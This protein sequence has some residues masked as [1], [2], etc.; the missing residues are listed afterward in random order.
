MLVAFNRLSNRLI[1][2]DAD[3]LSCARKA[4]NAVYAVKV[5]YGNA[6]AMRA[7]LGFNGA[8][9]VG[10]ADFVNTFGG[11]GYIAVVGPAFA[12]PCVLYRILRIFGG[13]VAIAHFHLGAVGARNRKPP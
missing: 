5:A 11:N 3:I 10:V 12:L 4:G 7:A 9:A 8:F 6:P 13:K 2:T 1:H